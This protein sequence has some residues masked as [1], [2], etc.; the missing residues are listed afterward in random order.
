MAHPVDNNSNICL[1]IYLICVWILIW[2]AG[3]LYNFPAILFYLPDI[4]LGL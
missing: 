4:Y 1:Y 2:T 3:L